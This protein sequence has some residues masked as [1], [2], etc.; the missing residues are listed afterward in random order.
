M[1]N[2][3]VHSVYFWLDP[4]L[5]AGQIGDF[6]KKLQGLLEIPEIR[7]G[8]IGKP[9]PTRRPVVDCTY[10]YALTLIFDDLAGHD[11]YQIH[12]LHRAFVSEC[13]TCWVKVVIYDAE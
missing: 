2:M 12:P 1:K 3:L 5:D 8:F 4:A 13:A 6:E 10:S 11:A 7:H 9:A